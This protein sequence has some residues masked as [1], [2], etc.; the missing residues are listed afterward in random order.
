MVINMIDLPDN[1]IT[2][3]YSRT[4]FIQLTS[5]IWYIFSNPVGTNDVMFLWLIINKKTAKYIFFCLFYYTQ[6]IIINYYI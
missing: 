1:I 3:R 6:Y 4:L 5:K 2:K